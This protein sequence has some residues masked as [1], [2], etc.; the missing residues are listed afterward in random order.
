MKGAKWIC[1]QRSTRCEGSWAAVGLAC[2]TQGGLS[3][4]N[5][6]AI[7]SEIRVA[8]LDYERVCLK[9]KERKKEGP[10]QC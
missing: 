6:R 3:A 7:T 2:L 1:G 4:E 5:K 9:K 10:E 8:S